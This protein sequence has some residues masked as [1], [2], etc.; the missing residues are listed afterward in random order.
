MSTQEMNEQTPD[1]FLNQYKNS[2][3]SLLRITA[4][5]F[6]G[7]TTWYAMGSL[8]EYTQQEGVEAT[9]KEIAALEDQI[10]TQGDTIKYDQTVTYQ[11]VDHQPVAKDTTTS[12]QT[13]SETIK[14]LDNQL[15]VQEHNNLIIPAFPATLAVVG[16]LMTYA[17]S[18]AND[19]NTNRSNSKFPYTKD[20]EAG[21][22][23]RFAEKLGIVPKGTL[24][25]KTQQDKER[26]KL[27]S[28]SHRYC[29]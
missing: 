22:W 21:S 25:L 17:L 3:F 15:K 28:S 19:R 23:N 11:M 26:L 29:K 4:P 9:Q 14:N 12:V 7:L 20:P 8:R 5:L 1:R 6:G 24:A 10:V 18:G 27:S 16:L 13:R 2:N